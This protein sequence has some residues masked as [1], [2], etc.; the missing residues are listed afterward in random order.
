MGRNNIE[1]GKNKSKCIAFS[2]VSYFTA[3]LEIFVVIRNADVCSKR[4][5]YLSFCPK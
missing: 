3:Y 4:N 1:E 5:G 2:L